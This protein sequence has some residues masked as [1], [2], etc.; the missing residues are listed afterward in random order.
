MGNFFVQLAV[1]R[2]GLTM[3]LCR[4]ETQ[5]VS[6]IGSSMYCFMYQCFSFGLVVEV[7][8]GVAFSG[9]GRV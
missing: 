4:A 7:V 9:G 5:Y 8:G 6:S 1:L 2:A 3:V